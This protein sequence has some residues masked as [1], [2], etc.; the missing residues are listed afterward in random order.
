MLTHQINHNKYSDDKLGSIHDEWLPTEIQWL[1]LKEALVQLFE[2]QAEL[3]IS[4]IN[5]IFT[6]KYERDKLWIFTCGYLGDFTKTRVCHFEKNN[7]QYLL[8]IIKF[9]LSLENLY[10]QP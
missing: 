4:F 8:L 3:L 7:C 5:A 1:S 6:L 10:P 2:L 9:E